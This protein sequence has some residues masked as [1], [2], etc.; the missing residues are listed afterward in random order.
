MLISYATIS[1][2]GILLANHFIS[3]FVQ[4]LMHWPQAMVYDEGQSVRYA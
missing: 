4:W 1:R 2:P 3:R